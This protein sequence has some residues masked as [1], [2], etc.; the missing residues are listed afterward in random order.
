[1]SATTRLLGEFET[2][3]EEVK[4]ENGVFSAW[5]RFSRLLAA[6]KRL[7]NTDISSLKPKVNVEKKPEK[8]T[9][10]NIENNNR[11]ILDDVG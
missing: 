7:L 4:D 3:Y 5:H 1:M 6:A 9:E 2:V 10:D 11:S 8:W